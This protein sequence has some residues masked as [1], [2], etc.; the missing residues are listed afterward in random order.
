MKVKA[1]QMARAL[2]APSGDVRLFLLYG[3]DES[4]S[5]A[6][7]ARLERAMGAGA[8]RIDLDGAA[9]RDDPARLSDEASAIAMFGDRRFIR[10]AGGDECTEAVD[11]LLTGAAGGNPVVLIAGALKPASMLLKR[12]LDDPGV[13]ACQ[14][15]KPEGSNLLDIAVAMGRAQGLN[16]SREIA[17]RLAASCLGDRAVLEREIEK[18]SLYLDAAPDRPRRVDHS[19]LDALGAGLDE[20]DTGALVDAVMDGRPGDLARELAALVG[21]A[22]SPVPVLR[23]IARRIAVL[24]RLRSDVDAGAR[25]AA[26]MAAAGKSLFYRE[27][28][29]VGRQI[30]QWDAAR[31]RI[32]GRKIFALDATLRTSGTAGDVLAVAELVAIARAA[33]RLR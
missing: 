33:E 4:G 13:L 20:L 24:A 31:L 27:R 28:D 12:V 1:D 3:P 2:D 11:A 22:T 5:R 14:S 26:V 17:A 21:S 25:P 19:T 8:E 23:A 10:I 7:A 30:A 18:L 29:A 15:F 16:L 9:L 32:A 6:F